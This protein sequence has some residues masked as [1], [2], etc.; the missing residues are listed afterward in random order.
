M[1]SVKLCRQSFP[2]SSHLLSYIHLGIPIS[3]VSLEIRAPGGQVTEGQKL[4]L[5]CSVTAG[6][7]NVTFSWYREATGTSLGMKTQ[8]SLSAELEIPAVKESDAGKY[9]CRADNGHE[10]I[11]SKVV[12]IPV[13]SE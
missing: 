13:R 8:H 10:S 4:I 1:E 7:G 2:Y 6:T 5:L 9:Y 11:Q 3:N 12:N